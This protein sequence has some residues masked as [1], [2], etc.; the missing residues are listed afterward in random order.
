MAD[1]IVLI[2][3]GMN[4]A[5]LH[6][7]LMSHPELW[8]Q[9]DERTSP[10][11]SPHNGL[12]DIWVRFVPKGDGGYFPGPA[13]WYPSAETLGIKDLVLN[14]MRSVEGT[15]LGGVLITRIP[16]R[17]LCRPHIDEGWHAERYEKFALQI[18]SA[19]GQKFCF[20][21]CSLETRPGDLFWFDNSVTHW[22]ENETDYERI[23]MIV[24]VRRGD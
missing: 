11:E 15:E 2:G 6:W 19:P 24:C 1:P 3:R 9:H 13:K 18:A 20:D 17:A 12:N 7:R 4:V 22:V 8:G 10:E 23:T 14:V 16:P 21:G 5:E